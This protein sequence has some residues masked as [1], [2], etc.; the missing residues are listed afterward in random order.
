[1]KKKLLLWSF[2]PILMLFVFGFYFVLP[3]ASEN[4]H[5]NY[6]PENADLVVFVNPLEFVKSYVKLMEANPSV[7]DSLELGALKNNDDKPNLDLGFNLMSKMGV[8][9]FTLVDTNIPLYGV[10]VELTNFSSFVEFSH[11]LFSFSKNSQKKRTFLAK[12]F[13]SKS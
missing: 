3:K 8:F 13:L 11:L 6:I 10:I 5:L 1:M 2:W 9:R 7:F 12:L 4:K